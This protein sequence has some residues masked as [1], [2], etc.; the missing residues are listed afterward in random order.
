MQKTLLLYYIDHTEWTTT[1][2]NISNEGSMLLAL[3]W[4]MSKI[5]EFCQFVNLVEYIEMIF[6]TQIHTNFDR[7]W[8]WVLGALIIHPEIWENLGEI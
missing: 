8:G 4:I 3:C 2:F 5:V 6:M 1:L 7:E